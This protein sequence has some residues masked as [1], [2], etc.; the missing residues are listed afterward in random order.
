VHKKLHDMGREK[1]ITGNQQSFVD[2]LSGGM[3]SYKE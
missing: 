1:R 2:L 3:I